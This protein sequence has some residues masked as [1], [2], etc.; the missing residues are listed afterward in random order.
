MRMKSTLMAIA[1]AFA[2][3]LVGGLLTDLDPWYQAL[4]QPSWK[5]PDSWFGPAW[6]TIFLLTGIAAALCWEANPAPAA[7]RQVWLFFSVNAVANLSWSLLFFTLKLPTWA[8]VEVVFLWLSIVSLIWLAWSRSHL[9]ALLLLPYL[10]W[11]SFAST[12]NYGV[13]VLN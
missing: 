2:V 3:A 6:T 7:R 1:I 8:L 4:N 12:V 13:T 9:A 11:V 10:G 5:P